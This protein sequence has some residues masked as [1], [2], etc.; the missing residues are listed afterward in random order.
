[1]TPSRASRRGLGS[2]PWALTTLAVVTLAVFAVTWLNG[3][4]PGIVGLATIAAALLAWG[5]LTVSIRVV[6]T[7]AFRV[8]AHLSLGLAVL[9]VALLYTL[10]GVA[11]GELTASLQ[12]VLILGSLWGLGS[13]LVLAGIFVAVA[14]GPPLRW[15]A[16]AGLAITAVW[17][18]Y[19]T[20]VLASLALRVL[21]TG[22]GADLAWAISDDLVPTLVLFLAFVLLPL[23]VFR[24]DLR[25]SG[26]STAPDRG[27]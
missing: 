21:A 7:A 2:R 1:M 16:W 10:L 4:P 14:A 22:V 13:M 5:A 27:S 18:A 25:E 24:R 17:G 26:R 3:Q 6:G 11:A 8:L 20:V 23:F 9:A 19:V 12:S 15:V